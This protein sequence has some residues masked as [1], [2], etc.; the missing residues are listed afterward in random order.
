L[1]GK[2]GAES[3]K[4]Q[5]FRRGEQGTAATKK[6][7]KSLGRSRKAKEPQGDI[8]ANY[9]EGQQK[10]E[11]TLSYERRTSGLE[12]KVLRGDITTL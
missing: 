6:E 10:K 9:L 7:M 8:E 4:P 2:K 11:P 5:V 1:I 12:E 3:G